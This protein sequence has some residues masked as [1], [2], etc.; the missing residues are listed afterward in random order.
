MYAVEDPKVD[1]DNIKV[2]WDKGPVKFYVTLSWKWGLGVLDSVKNIKNVLTT[3]NQGNLSLK[4]TK[5]LRI[6]L[7]NFCKSLPWSFFWLANV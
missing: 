5:I 6:W 7:K 2:I 1:E 4:V 3:N